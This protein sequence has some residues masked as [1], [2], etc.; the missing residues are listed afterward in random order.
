[1][2][3]QKGDD[4]GAHDAVNVGV[5]M[6]IATFLGLWAIVSI[7][8]SLAMGRWLGGRDMVEQF[9]APMRFRLDDD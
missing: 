4:D 5:P 1:M 2:G 3:V 6:T 8:A 7:V 9:M